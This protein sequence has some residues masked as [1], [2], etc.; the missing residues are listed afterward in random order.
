MSD[1]NPAHNAYSFDTSRDFLTTKTI[2]VTDGSGAEYQTS[3]FD[4]NLN[5]FQITIVCEEGITLCF[6][7]DNVEVM[8]LNTEFIKLE[9]VKSNNEKTSDLITIRDLL[10]NSEEQKNKIKTLPTGY[11]I[12]MVKNFGPNHE[13]NRVLDGITDPHKAI[14]LWLNHDLNGSLFGN[15]TLNILEETGRR[16]VR[17]KS[18]FWITKAI[19]LFMLLTIF[20]ICKSFKLMRGVNPAPNGCLQDYTF[21]LS[22]ELTSS[23]NSNKSVRFFLQFAPSTQ[24]DCMM[25]LVALLL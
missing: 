18:I 9:V 24:I 13:D 21:E 14:M 7:L 8:S 4:L 16:S 11:Q 23:M 6:N 15:R 10:V 25:T 20:F 5:I 2:K 3:D 12:S 17:N 22:S 19:V 1:K